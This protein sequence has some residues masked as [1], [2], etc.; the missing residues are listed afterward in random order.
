MEVSHPRRH[1]Q[2]LDGG[3]F[4]VGGIP[5]LDGREDQKTPKAHFSSKA[6]RALVVQKP[7]VG[8]KESDADLYPSSHPEA[9]TACVERATH[10]QYGRPGVE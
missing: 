1:C 8:V 3:Y 4:K 6:S 9:Q 7:L 10:G 2:I 5:A